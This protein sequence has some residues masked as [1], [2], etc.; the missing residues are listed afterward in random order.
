MTISEAKSYVGSDVSLCWLNRK[1]EELRADARVFSADFIP[2][3]GPCLVTDA[4][5]IRIDRVVSIEYIPRP[6]IA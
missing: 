5:D 6:K 3:Y 4:G 2:L 1:G